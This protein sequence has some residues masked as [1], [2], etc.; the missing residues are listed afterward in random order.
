METDI[1]PEIW[2][3]LSKSVFSLWVYRHMEKA[4]SFSFFFVSQSVSNF[5]WLCFLDFPPSLVHPW[6]CVGQ[7]IRHTAL[8]IRGELLTASPFD[9]KE[10]YRIC[11]GNQE[12]ALLLS[13]SSQ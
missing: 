6:M 10:D 3:F 2:T 11:Q 1:K 9:Y 12:G 13:I 4:W 8:P 7:C 5:L